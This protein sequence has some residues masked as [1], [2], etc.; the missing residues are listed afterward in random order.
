MSIE[1]RAD[2]LIEP[3]G[4]LRIAPANTALA[5]HAVAVTAGRIVAVG[6]APQLRERF[7]TGE[8]VVRERHALLPGLVNA[9]THAWHTLL[10]GLPV[11]GPRWRWLSEIMGPVE[12][13]CLSA[14]LV[15]DGTRL[16]VAEMLRA[17]ITCFADLSLFPEEAARAAAA[18]HMRAAIG[19]PVA[20]APTPWAERAAAAP[21][22]RARPTAPGIQRDRRR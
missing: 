7:E 1:E 17:G 20:D 2:L 21:A 3:R 13:R 11:R 5:Q 6:P 8:R 12:Q 19:L 22:P 16:G 15:R 14:D 10:R 9:H 4:L 18:A